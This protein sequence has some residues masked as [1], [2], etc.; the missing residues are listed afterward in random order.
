M[1]NLGLTESLQT[2]ICE[3]SVACKT[4]DQDEEV[5]AIG[6]HENRTD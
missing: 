5:E 2:S 4:A 3:R 6:E 1:G